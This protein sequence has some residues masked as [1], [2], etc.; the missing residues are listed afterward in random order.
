MTMNNLPT[1]RNGKRGWLPVLAG[2][3]LAGWIVS[4]VHGDAP[5]QPVT[6][7]RDV[8]PII[9]QHCAG[10][11][12]PGE[13][14]PFPLLTYRDVQ[15]RA[16]FIAAVVEKR[17]MPPW[18][19]V[20]GHGDFRGARRLRAEEIA[21]LKQWAAGGVVEGD[22]KHLPPVPKF[23]DGWQL[24]PPDLII[25]MVEP[26]TVPATGNDIYRNFVIP[27]AV[28]DGK[29]IRAAEYRPGNRRVVHHAALG[30]DPTG[31]VRKLEDAPNQG[32]TRFTLPGQLFPGSMSAWTPGRE[33][34]PLPDGMSLPW[35]KGADLVLQLHL[36][37]SGK[38]ETEQSTIGLYFT[39]RP[40]DRSMF[41]IILIDRKIDIPPGTSAYRTRDT[42][43]LPA[44]AEMFAIFPH[45]HLLGKEVKVT[46]S[47]PD[48]TRRS[49]LWI[50]DWDFKWQN[51]YEFAAPVKLPRGTQLL[52]ECVHDNSKDNPNQPASPP[53][54]VTWG[55]QT[56]DEMAAVVLQIAPV[57]ETE[58]GQLQQALAWRV[59]GRVIAGDAAAQ[60]A[61]PAPDTAG[62]AAA[63]AL[64]RFDKDGDGKLSFAELDAIP[65][66]QGL[67]I[68]QLLMPFDRDGDGK[69]DPR[70]LAEA[71]RLLRR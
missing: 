17:Y 60:A 22:P 59:V 20:E 37:P 45:M 64:R 63:E 69:L 67:N 46:A 38:V 29:Y 35:R 43:T 33:A 40:P 55:E 31:L 36:H 56:T 24:G 49:L 16:K 41:D 34:R 15:K 51:Y 21:I 9:L 47:L 5:Q 44:D 58:R 7:T 32:F 52:M 1:W 27:L 12:R 39:E 70:E 10:C 4:P 13:V 14:A 53:R 3:G 42:L 61:E 68:R 23:T 57:R 19:A 30:I 28:P 62:A 66:V 18:K 11:H 2:L 6:Y 8:A 54:R 48:G 26:Y 65:A 50:D 25:K 71:I